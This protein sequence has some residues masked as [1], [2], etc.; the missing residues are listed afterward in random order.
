MGGEAVELPRKLHPIEACAGACGQLEVHANFFGDRI[1][2]EI[3]MDGCAMQA[4]GA[5]PFLQIPDSLRHLGFDE[6]HP[7]FEF[8][9]GEKLVAVGRVGHSIKAH[10]AH[11]IRQFSGNTQ[12]NPVTQGLRIDGDIGKAPSIQQFL[13]SLPDIGLS[14]S[15]SHMQRQ[16]PV[17]FRAGERLIRRI[18]V[19]PP[20]RAALKGL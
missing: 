6:G 5:Q 10:A 11:E 13:Q 3:I 17:E 8:G 2:F 7:Q 1:A 18:K 15:A 12:C 14:Q 20:D 19:Y 4:V 16:Q 9:S